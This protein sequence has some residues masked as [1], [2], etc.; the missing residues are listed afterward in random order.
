MPI[1]QIIQG[2]CLEILKQMPD[3]CV[4][5]IITDPVWPNSHSSLIGS[6]NPYELFAAAAAEF[7]RISKRL[8]VHLGCTSDPRFLRGVPKEMPYIRTIWLR[9]AFPTHRGRILVGSDVAYMFGECPKVREGNRLMSGEINGKG[10]YQSMNVKNRVG[11]PTPRNTEH[12]LGLVQKFTNP[13]ELILDPFIGSGTT[14][15]AA[16]RLGRNFIGIKISE[17]YCKIARQRLAATPSPLIP[18]AA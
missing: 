14:A 15:V 6:E 7:P 11:H 17:K 12:L 8:I 2:D 16:K 1:N 9:Y 5:C 3:K 18:A 4:D 10:P 13:G